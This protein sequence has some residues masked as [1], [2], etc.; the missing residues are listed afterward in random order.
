MEIKNTNVIKFIKLMNDFLTSL[1]LKNDG[2]SIVTTHL[3]QYFLISEIVVDSS[4][5]KVPN[6]IFASLPLIYKNPECLKYSGKI[7]N[8]QILNDM[9]L[10]VNLLP[11]S[12][13]FF[14]FPNGEQDSF[15]FPAG[16]SLYMVLAHLIPS[17][18]YFH[19]C[20]I[21]VRNNPSNGK[22]LMIRPSSLPIGLYNIPGCI[23][24][25]EFLYIPEK[26]RFEDK[27]TVSLLVQWITER[28]I[29]RIKN[30]R[31]LNSGY[32]Q[33]I[34]RAK[35]INN[36]SQLNEFLPSVRTD[37]TR[38]RKYKTSNFT[39][40]VDWEKNDPVVIK[41]G[42]ETFCGLDIT[43]TR[44]DQIGTQYELRLN[45]IEKPLLMNIEDATKILEFL[46]LS[47]IP[48]KVEENPQ[49]FFSLTFPVR[50]DRLTCIPQITRESQIMNFNEESLKQ[51]IKK[52]RKI[53]QSHKK[54]GAE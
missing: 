10:S 31:P 21:F 9:L 29:Q 14:Q 44:F 3:S 27:F 30:G 54:F 41:S 7:A 28:K 8:Q 23:W 32:D 47:V 12:A 2:S 43:S 36:Y 4:F 26:F 50:R 1:H 48:R 45:G 11:D 13:I 49:M 42:I 24:S 20:L 15:I 17:Y 22:K 19:H 35:K 18:A 6:S 37:K 38:I 16:A 46:N 39:I 33:L 53:Y 34:S 51:I 40:M 5:S 25:I 52:Q